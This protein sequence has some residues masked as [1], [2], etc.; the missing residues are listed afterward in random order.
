MEFII[1]VTND[2][3]DKEKE[4]PVYKGQTFFTK[5]RARA[6]N[7]IRQKLGRL[8]K[9]GSSGAYKTGKKVLIFQDYFAKIGGIETAIVNLARYCRNT[10][11]TFAFRSIDF[12]NAVEIAKTCDVLLLNGRIKEAL[13][14]DVV[15][16]EGYEDYLKIKD[17]IIPGKVYQRC[18]ADWESLKKVSSSLKN[19]E[20][21]IDPAISKVLAVS[22]TAKKSLK[23]AFRKPIDSIVVP[24]CPSEV[25]NPL[26]FLTLSRLTMEKGGNRIVEMIQK[27]EEENVDYLWIIASPLE[28]DKVAKALQKNPKVILISP[29]FNRKALLRRVDYLVQLSDSES[30]SF[31]AREALSVGTPVIGT[32]IPE[33]KKLIKEGKNGYLLDLDLSN[34]DLKKIAK[35]P[36]FKPTEEKVSPLIDSMLQGEL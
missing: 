3:I 1:E 5:D 35:I 2:F 28:D 32:K 36:S 30:Y 19:Y 31:T 9:I 4:V 24:N 22:N 18:H 20:W 33:L 23:T 14:F 21:I 25:S 11:T 7:I 16:I 6:E 15:I 27:L 26:V 17:L 29:D 13:H 10:N 12:G 8:R 34:L